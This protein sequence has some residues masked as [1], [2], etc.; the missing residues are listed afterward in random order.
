MSDQKADEPVD[1]PDD[2]PGE[3]LPGARGTWLSVMLLVLGLWLL[4]RPLWFGFDGL[5]GW[6]DV[7]VGL[8]LVVLAGYNVRRR[9]GGETGNDDVATLVVVLGLYL[10]VTPFVFGQN[11][12]LFGQPNTY[13]LVN[14]LVVG[15]LVLF[16]GAASA[17]EA[18]DHSV[19]G[20]TTNR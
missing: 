19:P 5:W 4:S 15:L 8:L 13:A 1:R 3:K 12:G 20:T 17:Y 9:I 11:T 6:S 18:R 2:E 7:V 14:N 16:L 10:I